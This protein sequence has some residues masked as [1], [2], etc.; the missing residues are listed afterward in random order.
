MKQYQIIRAYNELENFANLPDYHVKEQRDI[1]MLRKML[2][3]HVEFQQ[4]RI[5]AIASK[6]RPFA[7]EKGVLEGQKYVEYLEEMKE[8]DEA[9]VTEVFEK[10]ELPMVEGINFKTMEVLEDFVTFT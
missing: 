1:F 2:R 7:N 9:E 8:L 4:E 5:D 3:P 6:Y 10:I